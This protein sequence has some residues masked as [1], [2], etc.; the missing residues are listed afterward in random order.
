MFN[1]NSKGFSIKFKNGITA[2]VQFGAMNYCE[3]RHRNTPI[4]PC[5][6]AEV[7]AWDENDQTIQEPI[8]W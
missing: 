4:F 8:G 5:E 7:M 2:S 1:A 3:N 6:N